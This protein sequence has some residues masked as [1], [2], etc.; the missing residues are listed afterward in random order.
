MRATCSPLFCCV[1]ESTFSNSPA[2]SVL[3]Q[4]DRSTGMSAAELRA[5]WLKGFDECPPCPPLPAEC[6]DTHATSG[7]AAEAAAASSPEAAVAEAEAAEVPSEAS[8]HVLTAQP[9]ASRKRLAFGG[10]E[11]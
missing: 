10:R 8:T 9:P 4:P 7:A 3:L 1:L 11:R 2:R 6:V 5:A